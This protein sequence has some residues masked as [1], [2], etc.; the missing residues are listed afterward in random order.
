MLPVRWKALRRL[1]RNG[2][3]KIDRK[4]LREAFQREACGGAHPAEGRG[5]RTGGE[6]AVPG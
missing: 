6:L 1:P 2:N 5:E 3:G 4:T